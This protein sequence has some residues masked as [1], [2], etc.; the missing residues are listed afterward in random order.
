MQV[1]I[2]SVQVLPATT[3]TG[4]PYEVLDIAFKN[5]TFQGKVEGKKL[6]PFGPNAGSFNV[7]KTATS[8]Q[9]YEVTVEK[10]SQGYN[11]WT[12]A[13]VSDGTQAPAQQAATGRPAQAPATN[14]RGFATPEERAATQVYIVRQSSLTAAV[15]TLGIGAKSA[16]DPVKVIET[17]KVYEAFV[18]GTNVEAAPPADG[19]SDMM[20]DVPL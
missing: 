17:A 8:G 15:N 9:V 13:A 7:L 10:N 2:L 11:D 20:D 4:K 6:M 1:Q 16:L 5:L 12:N 19:F 18:F 14:A 3:K